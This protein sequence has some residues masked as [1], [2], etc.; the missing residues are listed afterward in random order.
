[1]RLVDYL[2]EIAGEVGV[3]LDRA[4]IENLQRTQNILRNAVPGLTRPSYEV[5]LSCRA[6]VQT[7]L[8]ALTKLMQGIASK[9]LANAPVKDGSDGKFDESRDAEKFVY[10]CLDAAIDLQEL[11]EALPPPEYV[12]FVDFVEGVRE[13]IMTYQTRVHSAS[14]VEVCARELSEELTNMADRLRV[15]QGK[16]VLTKFP[17]S[18]AEA[19]HLQVI[20]MGPKS[21]ALDLMSVFRR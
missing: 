7:L 9:K 19:N 4:T 14:S 6:S 20:I 10:R 5:V 3:S 21:A 12:D 13:C 16:I 11:A 18:F 2:E 17:T 15:E 1:V 8:S